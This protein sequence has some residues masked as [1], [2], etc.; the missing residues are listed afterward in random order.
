MS[1][2]EDIIASLRET[3][4]KVVK[5]DFSDIGMEEP[6]NLDSINRISLIVE[7]EWVHD[8]EIDSD[9]LDPDVFNTLKGLA[10]FI[11]KLVAERV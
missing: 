5:K 8:V 7:L 9:G 1:S 11:E 4:T 2:K 6:L 3:L 10:D